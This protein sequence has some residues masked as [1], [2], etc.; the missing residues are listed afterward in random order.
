[1]TNLGVERIAKVDDIKSIPLSEL[2][3][4]NAQVRTRNTNKNLD[5]LVENIRTVG[6][7]QPIVV[8]PRTDEDG[9][10]VLAGQR[11]FFAHNEL[12]KEGLND[13]DE[14]MCVILDREVTEIEAKI[15]SFA[16]NE[17][18]QGMDRGDIVDVCQHFYD[19]YE[20]IA[21]VARATGISA[22]RVGQF[23]KVQTLPPEVQA[24]YNDN[25]ISLAAALR[26]HRACDPN[27]TG[28]V[29]PEAIISWAKT[30]MGLSEDEADAVGKSIRDP[31]E[32]VATVIE[33]SR[34][35]RA[36]RATVVMQAA[37]YDAL[38]QYVTDQEVTETQAASQL[39][40][41]G[42]ADQGYLNE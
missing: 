20:S 1:M 33:R 19:K 39:V 38:Q 16:E 21:E 22:N 4:G 14:I 15:I 30:M 26:A 36:F 8:C 41:E 3:I 24:A 25:E 28:D 2:S 10:Q 35:Q 37:V 29:E 40:E 27:Q 42:L 6:L 9:Y 13:F 18:R 32:D 5:A 7:L 23:L 11:R 12:V 34:S 17:A 31:N